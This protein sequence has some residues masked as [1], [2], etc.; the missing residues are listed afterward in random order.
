MGEMMT[1]AERKEMLS[2]PAG[3]FGADLDDIEGVY[4]HN[5]GDFLVGIE[6]GKIVATGA[7][8]KVTETSAELKRL[9][10]KRDRQR[11]GYGET[12]F[13]RMVER[14]KELGYKELMLDTL[15]ANATAQRLFKKRGFTELRREKQGPFH[16]STW[17]KKLKKGE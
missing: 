4:I 12:M 2:S 8:L 7:I 5:R 6:D 10:I 11:Q 1:E 3:S 17:G 14:G 9:R 15:A 13:R 16:L